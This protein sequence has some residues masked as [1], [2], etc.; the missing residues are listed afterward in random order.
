MRVEEKLL[1]GAFMVNVVAVVK[2]AALRASLKGNEPLKALLCKSM[3]ATERNLPRNV[4]G[5]LPESEQ[6]FKDRLNVLGTLAEG[7]TKGVKKSAG[8]VPWNGLLS[9]LRVTTPILGCMS[10]KKS[11]VRSPLNW[12]EMSEM[13]HCVFAIGGAAP[14]QNALGSDP[15]IA[16]R[17]SCRSILY[18]AEVELIDDMR[19]DGK[20][21]AI[22]LSLKSNEMYESF[23]KAKAIIPLG[24]LPEMPLPDSDID[25]D[26]PAAT[27]H[28]EQKSSTIAPVNLLFGKRRV[29]N[30][31]GSVAGRANAAKGEPE[32]SLLA[33]ST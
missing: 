17:L 25:M 22:L 24:M 23:E 11:G 15:L 29:T 4:D 21:P 8:T 13:V 9:R 12:L 5:K 3:I 16:F 1:F 6:F 10:W 14:V 2:L 28:P 33:K 19:V 26:P 32:S 7:E 31:T 18:V 27:M 30:L 20:D